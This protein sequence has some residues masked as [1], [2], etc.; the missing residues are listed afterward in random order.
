VAVR[1]K[2]CHVED[3]ELIG[4]TKSNPH[5]EKGK[6]GKTGCKGL[7]EIFSLPAAFWHST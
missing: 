3:G 6:S 7:R 1:I 5:L 2:I 4:P